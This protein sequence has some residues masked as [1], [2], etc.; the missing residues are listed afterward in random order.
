MASFAVVDAGACR[1]HG[2][3]DRNTTPDEELVSRCLCGEE[4]AFGLLYERYRLR[5]FATAYRILRDREHAQDAG[6]EIFA[7]VFQMLSSWDPSRAKFS[8]WLYRLSA[9]HAIDIWRLRHRK[10]EIPLDASRSS[11]MSRARRRDSSGDRAACPERALVR[12]ERLA[13]IRHCMDAFPPFQQRILVLRHFQGFRLQEI[14]E[15]EGRTLSTVKTTLH[16]ATRA[17]RRRLKPFRD[18]GV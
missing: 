12:Q 11:E 14:A 17:L 2:W 6:Q 8:T 16:R 10:P 13:A 18:F 1:M 7:K 9:N 5:V 15:L 3:L 4:E